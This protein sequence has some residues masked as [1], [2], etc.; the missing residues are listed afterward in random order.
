VRLRHGAEP[1]MSFLS[2]RSRATSDRPCR[3]WPH[4]AVSRP[5]AGSAVPSGRA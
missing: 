3:W 4:I 5:A 1:R 2:S